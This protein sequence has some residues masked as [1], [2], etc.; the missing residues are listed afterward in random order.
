MAQLR[1]KSAVGRNKNPAGGGGMKNVW[2]EGLA[3]G[4]F[5]SGIK[6]FLIIIV[7]QHLTGQIG[8][9]RH[10]DQKLGGT[11]LRSL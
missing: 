11:A 4:V 10:G 6:Y 3:G 2:L 5:V 7:R 9:Q 8:D 1:S